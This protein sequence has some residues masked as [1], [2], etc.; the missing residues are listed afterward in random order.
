MIFPILGVFCSV[1]PA[2]PYAVALAIPSG[3]IFFCALL[4]FLH[5][6]GVD[7]KDYVIAAAW[8]LLLSI[9]YEPGAIFFGLIASYHA[10]DLLLKKDKNKIYSIFVITLCL[11]AGYI[12]VSSI[13]TDNEQQSNSFLQSLSSSL[14][15]LRIFFLFCWVVLFVLLYFILFF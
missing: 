12:L 6:K 5:L 3:S 8:L 10:Y 13:L 4:T 14:D 7:Y 2:L 15:G 11:V 9:Y 1:L